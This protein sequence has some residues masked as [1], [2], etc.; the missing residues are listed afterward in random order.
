MSS[1][2]DVVSDDCQVQAL[3][4]EVEAA[5]TSKNTVEASLFVNRKLAKDEP[6][7]SDTFKVKFS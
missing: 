7:A 1:F 2:E 6:R 5:L 3:T 4:L